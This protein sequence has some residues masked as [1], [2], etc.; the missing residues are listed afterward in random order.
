MESMSFMGL[1]C[2]ILSSSGVGDGMRS[3]WPPCDATRPV[4]NGVGRHSPSVSI[5]VITPNGHLDIESVAVNIWVV[6][7]I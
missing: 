3:V 4:G 6:V 5:P 1:S 2:T 7:V